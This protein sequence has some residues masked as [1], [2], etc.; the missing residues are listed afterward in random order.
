[1][2]SFVISVGIE[3]SYHAS[4]EQ[5]HSL[6]SGVGWLSKKDQQMIFSVM[7]SIWDALTWLLGHLA[8]KKAHCWCSSFV[9][10]TYCWATPE[11]KEQF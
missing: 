6:P 7:R 9:Q 3:F 4:S 10:L 2:V 8:C 1:M 11:K 5:C